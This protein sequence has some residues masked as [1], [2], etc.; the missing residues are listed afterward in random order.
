MADVIK[1]TNFY[2]VP[3][4]DK[5]SMTAA[6]AKIQ[7]LVAKATAAVEK[8]NDSLLQKLSVEI[9]KK[10]KQK[11]PVVDVKVNYE[12]NSVT[13][14]LKEVTK[15]SAGALDP[16]IK[17]YQKMV[18][19]Q[20]ESALQVKQEIAIQKDK[21]QQL[22]QQALILKEGHRAYKKNADLQ[23]LTVDETKRLE[24]VLRKVSTLASLKGQLT[25]ESQKLSMMSQYNA[26]LDKQ[27]KLV[28]TINKDWAAQVAVVKGLKQQ[29]AAAGSASQSFG[30]KVATAGRN[31][32]GSFW[33]DRSRGCG[34][35]SYRWCCWPDYWSCQGHSVSQVD[36]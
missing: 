7:G 32:H 20:G 18:K 12:T 33:L 29:V 34:P 4:V 8:G 30:A 24:G 36:L 6:E 28:T 3:T 5:Q 27:G 22:K 13:G 35:D 26:G 21:L 16:M 10:T 11:A 19:I 14:G 23:K 31:M 1:G 25:A 2:I 15:L 9:A 17:D